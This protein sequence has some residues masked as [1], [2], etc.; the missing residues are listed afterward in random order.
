MGKTK[1]G[2]LFNGNIRQYG[3][4]IALLVIIVLF[5]ILTNGVLLY[6]QNV[7]N[8][9]MQNG[10]VII[11]A[12]GMLLCI[13]TGGNIDLSVGSVVAFTGAIAGS[14]IIGMKMDVWLGVLITIIVGFAI[15]AWQGFWIAYV[16]V[17][18]FIATLAGMLM[19][20]GL[21]NA[22]LKGL[23]L[24]PFPDSYLRLTGGFIEDIFNIP[25]INLNITCL[26]TGIV[27]IIFYIIF[28]IRSRRNKRKY[29]FEVIPFPLFILQILLVS[30]IIML[31]FYWLSR[32]KGMPTVLLL[33]GFLI[34]VYTF[35][36]QNTV[37]G[38][39]IYAIGGNEMAA[40][41]SGID[42]Q[43][44]MFFVYM[45][46]GVLATITGI[47]FSARLNAASPVAGTNFELDA[48]GACFIGGAS[49]SGGVGTVI[50]AVIGALVMGVLNNGMSILGVGTEWQMVIKGMVLLAAVA[51]DVF[52]K[53]RSKI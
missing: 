6:P 41:L 43:K 44:V 12:I 7:A 48:I 8:L 9:I 26:T 20:R 53:S 13:L 23:T 30:G 36:T 2:D 40:R 17:P 47:V 50:G 49:A 46:M 31:F 34:A 15:G 33:I 1:I 27:I 25:G 35:V 16:R 18:P 5:Q 51:F 52:S 32:Y 19:F 10:Y 4:I 11:L 21:T 29:N 28:T 14:L 22:I 3:M 37:F 38:R 45:N 42:P 24:A 39:Y